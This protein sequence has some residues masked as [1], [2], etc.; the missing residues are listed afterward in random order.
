MGYFCVWKPCLPVRSWP[1]TAQSRC[2]LT[3]DDSRRGH[4]LLMCA[5]L[6]PCGLPTAEERRGGMLAR[7]LLVDIDMTLAGEPLGLET[8]K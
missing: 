5:Q 4:L 6:G 2:F 3:V 7:L 1:L 8:L